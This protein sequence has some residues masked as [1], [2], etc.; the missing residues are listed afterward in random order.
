M[1]FQIF[2]LLF[3]VTA[4]VAYSQKISDGPI[5]KGFIHQTVAKGAEIFQKNYTFPEVGTRVYRLLMQNLKKGKYDKITSVDTLAESLNADMFA[6]CKDKH[7]GWRVDQVKS[8]ANNDPVVNPLRTLKGFYKVEIL[9]GNI[10]Y[11]DIKNF[12]HS[13]QATRIAAAAMEFLAETDALIFDLRNNGGG[14]NPEYLLGFLFDK[15]IAIGRSYSRD[16]GK[17]TIENVYTNRSL[18]T[19]FRQRIDPISGQMRIDTLKS[20]VTKIAT[21]KVYVLTSRRT[22]SAAESFAYN[23]QS[24]DRGKIIG[25]ITRGG[26]HPTQVDRVNDRI[27]I[28]TPYGRSESF[29]TK[30]DWEGVGVMPDIPTDALNAL[31]I[32]HCTALEEMIQATEDIKRKEL[33]KW[34]LETAKT[35]YHPSEANSAQMEQYAGAYARMEVTFRSNKLYFNERGYPVV[36]TYMGNDQFILDEHNRLQFVRRADSVIS[37]KLVNRSGAV[38]HLDKDDAKSINR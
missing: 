38:S 19:Y 21:S 24:L 29:V 31:E 6:I 27:I 35:I 15:P 37:L 17:E 36:L 23:V 2:V 33:L 1:R 10:G 5:D 14:D 22:F 11:V 26:A 20:A 34:D 7:A 32:A 9:P 8:S 30:T 16:N 12:P 25:E 3:V 28:R 4:N 18:P 13:D